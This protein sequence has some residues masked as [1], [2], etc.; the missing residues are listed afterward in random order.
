[1]KTYNR[2]L[3]YTVLALSEL[4]N[5]KPVLAARLMAEAVKQPD[6]DAAITLI[7]T[8]NQ[9]AFQM[10]AKARTAVKAGEEFPFGEQ[11]LESSEEEVA[12]DFDAD[13][14]EE[15]ADAEPE[16]EPEMLDEEMEEAPAAQ[17]AKV[18]SKM[19]RRAGSR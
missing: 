5:G 2:A 14:L 6:L 17:M 10:Q 18:L 1:M 12:P 19:K 13:P 7:E 16:A 9:Y 4:K 11:E 3:D 8:N 15:V